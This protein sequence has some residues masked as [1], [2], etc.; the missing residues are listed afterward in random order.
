MSFWEVP[1]TTPVVGTACCF[2]DVG[3]V[4]VSGAVSVAND[5]AA[6]AEGKA[7]PAFEAAVGGCI[8]GAVG[9]A[10]AERGFVGVFGT[11]G[12]CVP[13]VEAGGVDRAMG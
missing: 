4:A 13:G 2:C 10:V 8:G 1:L 6:V 11:V 5:I 7:P 9:V 12:V 3:V